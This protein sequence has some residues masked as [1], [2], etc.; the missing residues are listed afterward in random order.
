[1]NYRFRPAGKLWLC[2][3]SISLCFRTLPFSLQRRLRLL[4]GFP[5]GS[6]SDR[7]S[8]VHKECCGW[9]LCHCE[10]ITLAYP[11]SPISASFV[12]QRAEGAYGSKRPL[13]ILPGYIEEPLYSIA[14]SSG[15]YSR[16][17]KYRREQ[18]SLAT[19][20]TF[21]FLQKILPIL[22]PISCL[23]NPAASSASSISIAVPHT[24]CTPPTL[25]RS[26]AGLPEI[27]HC[28][29]PCCFRTD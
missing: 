15:V 14:D 16:K 13:H 28:S 17:T 12:H 7:Y 23:I 26:L 3:A 1:L 24:T 21:N 9:G 22:P 18:Q 25:D 29:V 5:S 19:S 10:L 2:D 6:C 27:T 4:E 11:D 8:K 20:F